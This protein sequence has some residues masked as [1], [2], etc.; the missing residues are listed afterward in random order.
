MRFA[1][2]CVVA[3][4]SL[5]C[6]ETI[7]RIV[8]TVNGRPVMES[9]LAEQVRF[10]QFLGAK[11]AQ[12][13][14]ATEQRAALER[15]LDQMLLQEQMDSSKFVQPSAPEVSHKMQEL[16][17][18]LAA[19]NGSWQ[20]ML[21]RYNL[22]EAD[23]AEHVA[24]QLRTFHFLDVRFRPAIRID[25]HAVETYYREQLLPKMKAA[26]NDPVPLKQAQAQIQEI[27]VQQQMNE[28]LENWLKVL[29]TQTEIRL[30]VPSGAAAKI[31][32]GTQAA[33]VR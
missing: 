5:L 10:E 31:H 20:Q 16:R 6:A 17:Q 3:M 7:D 24:L 27:L 22:S 15:L 1:L 12:V 18:Q 2:I 9:E 23:V 19:D 33:E 8:A 30:P 26:G 4:S 28:L 11:S 32:S 29:R 21:L 13:V 25:S 14:P